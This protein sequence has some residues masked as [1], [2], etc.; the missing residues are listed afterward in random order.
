MISG[1]EVLWLVDVRQDAAAAAAA[2][3]AWRQT[4]EG[5][6]LSGA[7]AQRAKAD[8]DRSRRTNGM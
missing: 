3:A 6:R 8:I 4:E 1:G 7:R 5:L 2:V